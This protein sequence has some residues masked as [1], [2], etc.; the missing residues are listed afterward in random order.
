M[1]KKPVLYV[2]RPQRLLKKWIL[3][4]VDHAQTEIIA[5]SPV[6]F[7]VAQFLRADWRSCDR[8]SSGTIWTETLDFGCNIGF[9]NAHW[10]S[11]GQATAQPEYLAA[12]FGIVTL[13]GRAKC[14]KVTLGAF[15]R[16]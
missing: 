14:S 13:F 8:G 2:L 16:F 10:I 1:A 9:E 6:G 4:Q 11:S 12:C 3:L 15:T 7:Y 5:S